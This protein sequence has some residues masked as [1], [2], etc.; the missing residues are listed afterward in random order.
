MDGMRMNLWFIVALAFSVWSLLRA[1]K[2][3]TL[4]ACLLAAF[5]ICFA[6]RFLLG[7]PQILIPAFLCLAGYWIVRYRERRRTIRLIKEF[8]ESL[9]ISDEA[10]LQMEQESR[11]AEKV[12]K[13]KEADELEKKKRRA[14]EEKA[15]AALARPAFVPITGTLSTEAPLTAVGGRLVVGPGPV[16]LEVRLKSAVVSEENSDI[17]VCTRLVDNQGIVWEGESF[18]SV[19]SWLGPLDEEEDSFP[20]TGWVSAPDEWKKAIADACQV[21][22]IQVLMDSRVYHELLIDGTKVPYF[23]KY[24]C[25]SVDI[26]WVAGQGLWLV[27]VAGLRRDLRDETADADADDEGLIPPFCWTMDAAMASLPL[28]PD[29]HGVQAAD[30]WEE[31]ADGRKVVF[32]KTDRKSVPQPGVQLQAGG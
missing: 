8:R 12:R 3:G 11:I 22:G 6:L 15:Y 16:Q 10:V 30:L 29:R 32:H 18:M 14:A 24:Q 26:A 1:R 2:A 13:Q 4:S 27:R 17:S 5:W 23:E 19:H 21:A 28:H 20:F 7:R 25:P 9:D 31:T